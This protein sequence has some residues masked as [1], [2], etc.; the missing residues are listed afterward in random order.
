MAEIAAR[1]IARLQQ[2]CVTDASPLRFTSKGFQDFRY[3]T[4]PV[5]LHFNMAQKAGTLLKL[6]KHLHKWNERW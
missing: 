3:E 6:S 1:A 5:Y 4:P 2:I